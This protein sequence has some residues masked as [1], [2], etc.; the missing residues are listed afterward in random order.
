[1]LSIF[2]FKTEP[3]KEKIENNEHRPLSIFSSVLIYFHHG[4]AR[5][6]LKTCHQ[7]PKGKKAHWAPRTA[8]G[9]GRTHEEIKRARRV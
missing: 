4:V 5:K 6:V 8:V 1:M 2:F 7:R 3:L 9:K